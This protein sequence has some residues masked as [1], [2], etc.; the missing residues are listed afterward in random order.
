MARFIRFNRTTDGADFRRWQDWANLVLGVW[1]FISPWL[2]GF[3]AGAAVVGGAPVGGPAAGG[4]PAVATAAWDAWIFGIVIAAV[5]VWA[6]SQF[7]PWQEWVN[8][9]VGI[10]LFIAPWILG[11]SGARNAAWDHWVVGLVVFLI[12]LSAL[13]L[14]RAAA[15][16]YSHAGDKPREPPVDRR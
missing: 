2:L 7:A 3:A 15:A 14:P 4:A 8:M 9:A 1:L 11:F 6:M 12:S 10:W 5:A 16:H 13:S